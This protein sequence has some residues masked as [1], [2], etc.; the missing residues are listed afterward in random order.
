MLATLLLGGLILGPAKG[1][2]VVDMLAIGRLENGRWYTAKAEPNDPV[3]KTGAA[4]YYPLS[5][6]GIGAPISLPKLRFDEEVAPGWYIEYV[7]K[8]AST[9]L[10]TGTPAKAAKVV[11]YSPTS[12]TYVDV[13]KA[14]LQAKG[15][16]NSKPRINAV[17]GVDLDGD[18]TREILIE[19][20]PKADMRGTTMGENPNK[21]DYTS[22]LV[23]YVSG[24]KVVTKVIAHHDAKSGYLSDADQLRGLAD[25][26]GDGVLEIVTSSNYYEG[27]SAAVWNFKKGKLIKL[28]ENGSGV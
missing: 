16:K 4:K 24:S 19:A 25:L 7:E 2:V 28:V 8:A 14:H 15:L 6:S 20:A 3:G 17:Y 1:V 27:S 18:G 13:V 12:K 22:I 9:A 5:M 21:A 10:W 11:K 23:R 26:D